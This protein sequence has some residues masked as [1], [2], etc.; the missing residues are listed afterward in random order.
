MSVEGRDGALYVINAGDSLDRTTR[1]FRITL[2]GGT[3]T[4]TSFVGSS[5]NGYAGDGK[6]IDANT[7][8][9]VQPEPITVTT[10]GAPITVRPTVN[11]IVGRNGELI[12]ADAKEQ[13][14][15]ADS[16]SRSSI[17]H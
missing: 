6:P 2:S 7:L 11:I 14:D 3:G 10:V 12:F 8:I 4:V 1:S 9:D 5:W 16:L 13:C 15:P 17:H